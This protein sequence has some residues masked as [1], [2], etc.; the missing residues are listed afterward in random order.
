MSGYRQIPRFIFFSLFLVS[1]LSCATKPTT[2]AL[3]I[4]PGLCMGCHIER[5]PGLFQ[6]WVESSR[7]KNGVN[8]VT[9]HTDHEAAYGSKA[10]EP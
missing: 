1:S 3:G 7:A 6:A 8:C 4:D 2:K 5:T 10:M 9:C